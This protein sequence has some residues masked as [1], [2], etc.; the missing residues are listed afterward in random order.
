M[1]FIAVRRL[2]TA[3]AVA[4]VASMAG[5]ASA[6]QH[7]EGSIGPGSRYSLDLPEAWNGDLVVYAHGIVD[8]AL[9]VQLPSSQDGFDRIRAALLERGFAVAASSFSENGFAL[10]DATQRTHQLSGL[11]VAQFGQPRRVLLA[12]HSLGSMAALQLT[13]TFPTAYDG[14]LVMCGFVG[15]TPREIEYMAT[16][17]LAFDYFFPGVI[18][19]SVFVIPGSL[20]YRPPSASLPAGSPLFAA[21]LNALLAGLA[22]PYPTIQLAIAA[23]LPGN[24]PAEWVNS[25][26]NVIGFNLRYTRNLL[27]HTN[28][29]I[30]FDNLDVVYAHAGLNAGIGRLQGSPD[31]LAYAARYYTPTAD[32]RVPVQ[33]LHSD[34]DP[35]VPVWHEDIYAER[36]VERGTSDLLQQ[37]RVSAYGHCAFTDAQVL[38]AFDQLLSR[39]P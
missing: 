16:A 25:A 35:V 1:A 27:E 30:P 22:P 18:P 8:P 34:R 33:T 26:L 3:V 31:A 28:G 17:R 9:A 21:V 39:L 24:G 11:F 14:A 15:G 13:E 5:A 7:L 20:D 38:A 6:Q 36:A 23:G 37:T 32:L 29:H 10:K 19:G 2:P 12:G 4:L